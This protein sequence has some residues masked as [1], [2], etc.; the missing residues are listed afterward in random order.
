ML[1]M[2]PYLS[3]ATIVVAVVAVEVTVADAVIAIVVVAA[4][5]ALATIATVH[6]T[7][8]RR[9]NCLALTP[10]ELR[11]SPSFIICSKCGKVEND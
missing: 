9:I 3:V 4:V 11:R 6:C 8:N 1:T 5:A 2:E 7:N 10:R